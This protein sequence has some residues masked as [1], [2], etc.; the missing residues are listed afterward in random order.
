MTRTPPPLDS[1]RWAEGSRGHVESFFLKA[2]DPRRP[3]QA[4]WLK[5]T[6]LAPKAPGEPN[7]AEVWAIRFDG[8]TGEHRAGK[9]SFKAEQARLSRDGLGVEVGDCLL[10]PGRTRG[11]VGE[12]ADRLSWDLR[13]EYDNQVPWM[14]LPSPWMYEGGFPKNKTY[15]S[16]PSTRFSGR[17]QFG[18]E[19]WPVEGWPGM[20]G[21][22][23]GAFH[24]PAYHWAQ[25]NLFD[26]G[27][28]TVFEGVSA[29]L[30][31]GPFLSPWVTMA[32]V[33]DEGEEIPF[34][35]F[36]RVLNGSVQ[37]GFFHW[38]FRSR[39]ASWELNWEVSAQREDFVGLAY[40][41][42]DGGENHCLNSKIATARLRLARK[43]SSG[44]EEVAN[45][46]GRRSCAYEILT[47][48]PDHGVPVLA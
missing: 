25:C 28:D 45:L 27:S 40:I 41:D 20:L 22:N 35:R 37:T 13:F 19:E 2:N 21:H 14:S 43:G 30:P 16:C 1:V 17:L 15:S 3:G 46:E 34:N 32:I 11:S 47:R 10:E 5:F 44:W 23:W 29:R 26:G 8:S 39:Q 9:S 7:L 12:G 38:A 36:S 42:P 24:N 4:F 6:L 18:E 48:A 33:R 31:L